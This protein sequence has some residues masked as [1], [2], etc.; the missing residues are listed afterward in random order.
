MRY[1]SDFDDYTKRSDETG[2]I[3]GEAN[4]KKSMISKAIMIAIHA[5]ILLLTYFPMYFMLISSLKNNDQISANCF[6]PTFP[7]R[8]ENYSAAFFHVVRYLGN[9]IIVSGGAVI[10]IMICGSMSAYIFARYKFPGKNVLY[11]LILS[12]L[13]VPAVLT[14]IP[15]FVLVNNLGLNNTYWSCILPYIATGQIIFI[16]ILRTFIEEIPK[17]LFDAARIDGAGNARIFMQVVFPLSKQIIVSL[18]LINFL[19]TWN[20]FVWPQLTLTKDALK[21]VTVGLFA[22]TDAQ[23]IQYGNMFAGFVIASVPLIILFS[24][25]MKSF[26]SGITIGAVKG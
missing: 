10:G 15:Q 24:V 1:N 26:V 25:N 3:G 2:R 12:F 16:V 19:N 5:V 9:S 11:I 6:L 18:L 8:F 14:L 22:F 23:Q 13:M 7:L 20:D 4:A 21:T 17:D